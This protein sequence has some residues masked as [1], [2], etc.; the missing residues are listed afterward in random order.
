MI[1]KEVIRITVTSQKLDSTVDKNRSAEQA[2]RMGMSERMHR[3]FYEE[4][5]LL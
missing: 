2:R 5:E 1:E 4:T 3:K